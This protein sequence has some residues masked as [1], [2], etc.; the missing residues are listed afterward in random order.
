MPQLN[1]SYFELRQT[2]EIADAFSRYGVE[3]LFIGKGGAIILGYPGATQD[4][5]LFP[6]KGRTNAEGILKALNDLGFPVTEN[7]A[8][9]ILNGKDFVQIKNGPYELDLIFAPDGIESFDLAK[10]RQHLVDGL[11]VANIRDIIASKRA[12]GR[13]KD[14]VDL[15]LLED[16]RDEYEKQLLSNLRTTVEIALDKTKPDSS[17]RG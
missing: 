16:F 17:F 12:A 13:E 9:D 4:V 14:L 15:P 10:S 3:F 6:K 7:I 5:D 8:Q 1:Q 2:R 11:P